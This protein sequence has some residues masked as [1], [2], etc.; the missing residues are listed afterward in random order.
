MYVVLFFL[1]SFKDLCNVILQDFILFPSTKF[2]Y[3]DNNF[4]YFPSAVKIRLSYNEVLLFMYCVRGELGE[5]YLICGE[6]Y[7]ELENETVSNGLYVRVIRV[8]GLLRILNLSIAEENIIDS[9]AIKIHMPDD[10]TK[11]KFLS[12]SI[13]LVFPNQRRAMFITSKE[14][15]LMSVEK[16]QEKIFS[17]NFATVINMKT[18]TYKS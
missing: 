17:R 2:I 6:Q 1:N 12:R 7:A 14:I 9:V 16:L 5:K 4:F 8:E 11:I 13:K 18:Y 10:L 3:R 15:I